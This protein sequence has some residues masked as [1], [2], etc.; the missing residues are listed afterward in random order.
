M[1]G[2]SEAHEN[3]YASPLTAQQ[4]ASQSSLQA[5]TST[6]YEYAPVDAVHGGVGQQQQQQ[7][8]QP[9]SPLPDI[10]P[11]PTPSTPRQPHTGERDPFGDPAR[12]TGHDHADD[13]NN[14]DDA[15]ESI[16]ENVTVVTEVV[17]PERVHSAESYENVGVGQIRP[18]AHRSQSQDCYENTEL[19]QP[20]TKP[21][22]A[23]PPNPTSYPAA[24][25]T[26]ADPFGDPARFAATATTTADYGLARSQ[27]SAE[28]SLAASEPASNDLPEYVNLDPDDAT[29]A[30]RAAGDPDSLYGDTTDLTVRAALSTVCGLD[31]EIPFPV[32]FPCD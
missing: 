7:L 21:S 25:N 30:S 14:G 24:T 12:F 6:L 4:R 18:P 22:T 16:Y 10:P 3:L 11:T 29:T 5:G 32:F 8:A 27:S 28:Y 26:A 23:P 20:P 15:Q 9:T 13:N 19:I 31:V 2:G 17:S 1:E